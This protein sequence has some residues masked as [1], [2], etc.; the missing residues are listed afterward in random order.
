MASSSS[1]Y[2]CR[3]VHLCCHWHCWLY[4][5]QSQLQTRLLVSP[6]NLSL[7]HFVWSW[8]VP[9]P[10][11]TVGLS[12]PDI[13]FKWGSQWLP[14]KTSGGQTGETEGHSIQVAIIHSEPLVFKKKI[15]FFFPSFFLFCF[16]SFFRIALLHI[17]SLTTL[18][19]FIK[20]IKVFLSP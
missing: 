13:N 10:H 14:V 6:P 15:Q 3:S 9:V 20:Y 2:D 19:S 17:C 16:L 18:T 7:S 8:P 4:H 1:I 11:K 5:G 12:A